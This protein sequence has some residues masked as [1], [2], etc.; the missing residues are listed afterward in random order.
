M[1]LLPFLF[2]IRLVVH[3]DVVFAR[4]LMEDGWQPELALRR[5]VWTRQ[6]NKMEWKSLKKP[7]L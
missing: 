1:A 4:I 2:V 5:F 6:K 3:P 7:L